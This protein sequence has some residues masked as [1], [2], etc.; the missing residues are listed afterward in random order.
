MSI[1]FVSFFGNASS[2]VQIVVLS[3]GVYRAFEIRRGFAD[4]T[5]RARALASTVFM[6]FVIITN[7]TFLIPL[8]NSPLGAVIGFVPFLALILA[9]F[10]LVD[11]NVLA[12]TRSDFFHRSI[13][14]WQNLRLSAGVVLV[15]SGFLISTAIASDPQAFA[16]VPQGSDPLWVLISYYQ[17]FVVAAAVIGYGALGLIV[18]SRRTPDRTLKRHIRLLGFALAMFVLSILFYSVG[19]YDATQIA[20]N[21]LTLIATYFLYLSVMSLTPLGHRL[22]EVVAVS[23]LLVDQGIPGPDMNR[24]QK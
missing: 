5:Y 24:G 7:V 18:G 23:P 19:S 6:V 8:P 13:I 3:V 10:A 11:S 21:L 9:S 15:G 2:A 12:A 17:F 14:H 22:K 1:D 20:G 4:A 16:S